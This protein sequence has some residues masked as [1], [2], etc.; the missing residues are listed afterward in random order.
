M[1]S[2]PLVPPNRKRGL[3]FANSSNGGIAEFRQLRLQEPKS[4]SPSFLPDLPYNLRGGD[5]L[6]ASSSALYSSDS[7]GVFVNRPPGISIIQSTLPPIIYS[8]LLSSCRRFCI[9]LDLFEALWSLLCCGIIVGYT[10]KRRVRA[11]LPSFSND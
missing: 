7:A 5:G 8:V 10:L 11:G 9:A 4:G 1:L 6:A 3:G 2:C